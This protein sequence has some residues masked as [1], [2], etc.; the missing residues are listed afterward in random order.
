MLIHGCVATLGT[1]CW[2][3]AEGTGSPCMIIDPGID[4]AEQIQRLVKHHDLRPMGVLI[5]HGHPDHTWSVASLCDSYHIP[6]YIHHADRRQ[7]LDPEPQ[8]ITKAS[9]PTAN[10]HVFEP[11]EVVCDIRDQ[12]VIAAG[13]L[14]LTVR[15]VPG[16]TPGS[17]MFQCSETDSADAEL[18]TGDTLFAGSVG[19][20]DIPGGD[21]EQLLGSLAKVVSELPNRTRIYPGH[22]ACSTLGEQRAHNPYLDEMAALRTTTTPSVRFM[23]HHRQT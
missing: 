1:N 14:R 3:V 23:T 19:R 18:F 12:Q 6:A 17:V 2:I 20:T 11:P 8:L 22:G 9:A 13:E 10:R 21:Y 16:H 4:A 7:L 5:T 15:H